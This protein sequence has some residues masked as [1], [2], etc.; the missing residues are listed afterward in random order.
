VPGPV[1]GLNSKTRRSK[2]GLWAMRMAVRRARFAV[3]PPVCAGQAAFGELPGLVVGV[4]VGVAVALGAAV[5]GA[6]VGVRLGAAV[7]GAGV[8]AATVGEA[9]IRTVSSGVQAA[10]TAKVTKKSALARRRRCFICL[11]NAHGA[12]ACRVR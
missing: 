11:I 5:V 10:P 3:E 1:L 9:E 12:Q 7:V 4:A 2:P 8:V 6:A